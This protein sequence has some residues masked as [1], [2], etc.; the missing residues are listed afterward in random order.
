MAIQ[1][2]ESSAIIGVSLAASSTPGQATPVNP[3]TGEYISNQIGGT[4]GL[5]FNHLSATPGGCQGYLF[6]DGVALSGLAAGISSG[7]GGSGGG[8]V[9]A[10]VIVHYGG[11]VIPGKT[12]LNYG[13]A[14][15]R[16]LF[17]TLFAKFGTTYGSGDGSTTFNLPDERGRVRASLDNMGGSAAGRLTSATMSPNGS[18]LGATGGTETVTVAGTTGT[19]SFDYGNVGAGGITVAGAGHTHNYSTTVSN[20]QPTILF[21]GITYTG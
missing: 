15:S 3:G 12:L 14:V 9:D 7:G 8:G 20:V 17:P 13:Q 11:G 18:T 2:L 19:E 6:P 4:S 10:G 16:T 5:A 21:N 1:K